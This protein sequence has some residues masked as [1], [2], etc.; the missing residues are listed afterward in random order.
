MADSRVVIDEAAI[1]ALISDW[2]NGVGRFVAERVAEI[3]AVAK[4]VAPVSARGSEYAATGYLRSRISTAYQHDA[5]GRILGLVGVPL[6]GGSRYPLDFVV[7][8]RGVTRNANKA[9]GHVHHYGT[10]PAVNAFLIRAL[11]SI[12]PASTLEGPVRSI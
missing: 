7:N 3:E 12:V 9:G 8:E 10:R 6:S 5:S 2:D 1:A 4:A 11:N